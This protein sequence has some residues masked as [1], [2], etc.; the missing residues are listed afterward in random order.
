MGIG[1]RDFFGL[2]LPP[3]NQRRTMIKPLPFHSPFVIW[4]IQKDGEKKGGEGGALMMAPKS[5]AVKKSK[6][7]ACQT[8]F[9]V[10]CPSSTPVRCIYVV[11]MLFMLAR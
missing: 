6:N 9:L 11:H 4:L 7:S 2:C 1:D 8:H 5:S 10:H 3:P